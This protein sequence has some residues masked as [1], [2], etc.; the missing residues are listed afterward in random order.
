MDKVM[1]V[2]LDGS[3]MLFPAEYA[4]KVIRKNELVL[5]AVEYQNQMKDPA[6]TPEVKRFFS[7]ELDRVMRSIRSIN[8][9]VPPC[10]I[11]VREQV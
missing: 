9:Q 8:R 2:M 4:K 3:K 6:I 5:A 10:G 11:T 1:I 7:R